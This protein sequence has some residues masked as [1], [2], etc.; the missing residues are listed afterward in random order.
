MVVHFFYS[1]IVEGIIFI[2]KKLNK[3]EKYFG[4]I[5]HFD[6][7]ENYN[8]VV[9]GSFVFQ[10]TGFTGLNTDIKRRKFIH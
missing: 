1:V 3:I 8:Y 4:G 6:K 2:L 10:S 9:T 5:R 7:D